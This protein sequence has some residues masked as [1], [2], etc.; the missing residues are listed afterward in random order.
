MDTQ[1]DDLRAAA[2]TLRTWVR[3]MNVDL[4]ATPREST[5]APPAAIPAA[6]PLVPVPPP[7]P[8]KAAPASH[9]SVVRVP[10]Q[11]VSASTRP[12]LFGAAAHVPETRLELVR[13]FA[14][15]ADQRLRPLMVAI[16]QFLRPLI[17]AF[18]VWLFRVAV[19]LLERLRRPTPRQRLWNGRIAWTAA[20]AIALTGTV[21]AGRATWQY[22][23]SLPTNGVATF[24][25]VPD[26]AEVLVDG[27]LMGKTP[28][29][30]ELPPGSHL[31]EFKRRGRTRSV[32]LDIGN[33]EHLS[34]QVDWRRAETGG[35]RVQSNPAGARV[36]VD[37]KDRGATPLT[38]DDILVGSHAV[39]LRHKVG[40]VRKT[41][42]V[43]GGRDAE[44]N[45]TIK[46][47]RAARPSA[48]AP[49]PEP[50]PEP[51]QEP[52]GEVAAE[53]IAPLPEAEVTSP[54]GI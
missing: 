20:A 43:T 14:R 46:P 31:V 18:A 1:Q 24:E 30:V 11:M 39:T 33:G 6:A 4:D 25:S 13:R 35:L 51:A 29:E 3:T 5:P 44:I 2:E 40:T 17:V 27:T 32:T 38:L 9:V 28:I 26:D 49:S 48:V 50:V 12:D 37:G 53:P 41:V 45:E 15:Q 47:G 42:T 8:A 52:S 7:S 34:R 54:S 36:I 21:W 10:V 23:H 19:A 16:Y 22:W